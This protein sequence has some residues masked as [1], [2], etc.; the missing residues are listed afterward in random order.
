VFRGPIKM[1]VAHSTPVVGSS[2]A[3]SSVIPLPLSTMESFMVMDSRPGY[4]MHC[5]LELSFLGRIDRAAFETGLAFALDRNPFF[6]FTIA[7]QKNGQLAWQDS[8]QSPPV[9]WI[10]LDDPLD[11]TYGATFDLAAWPGLRVW[12]LRGEDTSK[13]LLHFHHVC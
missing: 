6:R 11:D 12:V 10:L 9:Q 1:S 2:T 13:V 3:T 5:D 8:G 7:R 4:G